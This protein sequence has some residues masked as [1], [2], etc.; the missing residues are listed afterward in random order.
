MKKLKTIVKKLLYPPL[1][2]MLVLAVVCAAALVA[3]FL[4]GWDRHPSAPA[5]YAPSFYTLTVIVLACVRTFPGYYRNAKQKVIDHPVGG[6]FMTDM[7]FRTHIS[8]YFS[9]AVNLLYAAVNLFSG[10]WYWSV[11]FITLAVY[12]IILAAMRFLLVRFVNRVGIGRDQYREVRCYRLCGI[13]LLGLNIALSGVVILVIKQNKGFEYAG[14]LIYVM[15][16]YTFY[17][18]VSSIVNIVKYRRYNSPVM[19]AAKVINLAAGLVSMLSLETA[20]LS[21]FG[22]GKNSPYFNQ[23]MTGATGAGVGVIVLSI[24]VY[25]IVKATRTIRKSSRKEHRHG[26]SR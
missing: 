11:W 16:M 5:V 1:W 6:R 3:V 7:P 21:Q 14:I 26:K 13:I 25:M 15:A 23:I 4:K 12:Y 9:L 20:M 8:L 18:T 19:S 10:I 24:S 2:L 17:I 22:S